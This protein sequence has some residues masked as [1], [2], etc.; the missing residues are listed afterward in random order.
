[1]EILLDWN[2]W[3]NFSPNFKVREKYLKKINSLLKTGQILVIKG[4]RRAGKSALTYLLVM[5]LIKKGKIKKE[6]ALF[7]NFEDPRLPTKLE[8]KDIIKIYE[9]Y[10]E[11]ISPSGEAIIVLDEIQRIKGWE[12]AARFFSENK[13]LKVIVTGSS[14][15]LLSQEY[16]TILTGRHLDI[17]IFPLDFKEFLQFKGLKLANQLDILKERIKI[18]QKLAEFINY[19]GFPKVVLEKEKEKLLQTYFSDIVIK[20]VVQRFKIKEIEK[21]EQLAKWYITNI[22]TLQSFNRVKNYLKLSLDSVERFSFY[23]GLVGLCMFVPKFSY[24][25]KA[26]ILSPKKVYIIDQGFF[27]AIGFNFSANIGRV[28]ENVVAGELLRRFG[29]ENVFYWKNSSVEV[30][31]VLKKKLKVSQIIQVCYNIESP[32]TKKREIKGLLKAS[33]EL[34]CNN[35]L[36]ITADYEG[37]ETVVRTKI[38]RKVKYIP[39][40]KWLLSS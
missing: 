23:L 6:T 19:G 16:G 5:D 37:E 38:S 14:S 8:A 9:T 22:S 40:W 29:K 10:L 31:F 20:D 3:G 33:Q 13:N 17:E 25:R 7:I 30:D 26:Q 32:E 4:V 28:Y 15:K 1:M 34:K 2:L 12:R 21:I 39:L 36:V 35:L 24:S 11:E 18:K 27:R